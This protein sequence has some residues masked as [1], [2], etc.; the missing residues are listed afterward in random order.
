MRRAIAAGLVA[1][2][3]SGVLSA[4]ASGGGKS[5]SR[6]VRIDGLRFENRSRTPV[7]DIQLLLPATGEFV[8]C[9][10]IAPGATCASRFPAVAYDG[11][12][13]QITWTQS[14]SAWSTGEVRLTPDAIIR[15]AGV[16]EVRVVVLA[17]GSAG[18]VLVSS[19]TH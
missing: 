9:G 17:P 6:L 15:A 4:C 5:S 1:V 3:L 8:S 10:H 2:L 13:L 16:A 14:G 18:A 7:S 11:S 19:E 12:P